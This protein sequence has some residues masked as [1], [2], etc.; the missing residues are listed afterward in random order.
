MTSGYI[1]D[2]G[3]LSWGLTSG[4][5]DLD[6]DIDFL[7]SSLFDNDVTN[8][9]I[10]LKKN[11]IL[12]SNYSL[13]FD[14]YDKK[15]IAN[16]SFVPSVASL[17]SIDYDD[18]GDNDLIVGTSIILYLLMNENGTF[19]PVVIGYSNESG[20]GFD[21]M[22]HHG[23]AVSDFNND[24]YDDFIMGASGGKIRLFINEWSQILK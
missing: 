11:K 23:L 14:T 12:E 15:I 6:G 9:Y 1:E 4:D 16:L 21:T 8:G 3:R 17:S 5:F 19:F 2:F 10:T 7:V 18:D 13:C 24:G 22:H 20:G